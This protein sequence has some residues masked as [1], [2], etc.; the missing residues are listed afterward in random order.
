MSRSGISDRPQQFT[1]ANSRQCSLAK[2]LVFAGLGRAH[3]STQYYDSSGRG[4][5]GTLT[6]MDPATDWVWSSELG[7]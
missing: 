2:G 4:N 6:A 1:L 3:G 7:R 5:N